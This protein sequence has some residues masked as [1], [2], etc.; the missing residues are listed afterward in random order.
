MLVYFISPSAL[1]GCLMRM[2]V[3]VFLMLQCPL[4]W[5]FLLWPGFSELS[6]AHSQDLMS[7]PPMGGRASHG[8]RT[9]RK[10]CF[11]VLC[12][13]CPQ[14]CRALLLHTAPLCPHRAFALCPAASSG[15]ML[16][17]PSLTAAPLCTCGSDSGLSLCSRCPGDAMASSGVFRA[18]LQ[19]L[20]TN[21]VRGDPHTQTGRFLAFP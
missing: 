2:L 15:K 18:D 7:D 8:Q 9:C 17:P 19:L 16:Q 12:P 11:A 13:A 3:L 6:L 10:P 14:L 20:P 5:T 21:Q 1:S 4:F